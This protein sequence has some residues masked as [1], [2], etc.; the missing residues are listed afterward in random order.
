MTGVAPLMTQAKWQLIRNN[1]ALDDA[2][3][4]GLSAGV[5]NAMGLVAN[6]A[7]RVLLVGHASCTTNNPHAAGLDC[8]ACGGQSGE[9]NVKL[10]AQ[11]LNSP[12]VRGEL[13]AHNIS[14]PENTRFVACLHN[15]TSD[16]LVIFED[17]F[18]Y[19]HEAWRNWL[20]GATQAAQ[21]KRAASL[22]IA[23]N[24]TANTM[25]KSYLAKSRNW[26]EIRP[27]WGLANNAAFI[28]APRSLTQHIDL[29]CRSFLHDYECTADAEYST[30]ELIITAPM[31]VTNWI[32][33]QYYA[34]V[35]DNKKYGSGNKLLHNV[36]GGAMGVFEGNGGDL[37]IGLPLQSIH[38]G[39]DWRHQPLR[40]SVYI[41]A[42]QQAILDIV[43]R[44]KHV[45]SLINNGWLYLFQI[46]PTA[47]HISQL[48]NGQW[49]L[50]GTGVSHA[51]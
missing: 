51:A 44:H 40:L 11:L 46:D 38:D 21:Q 26:S 43:S 2:A 17:G 15:T 25:H 1:K 19:A 33:M 10:L 36:V 35:T 4:A 5:L 14:I 47:N 41:A 31:V 50:V 49:T 32:N 28:V 45:E 13:L 18:A 39:K 30:L 6:F 3:L 29:Q 27:E 23:V 16:D 48:K 24:T 42:P 20:L 34:S 7:Q 37:R 8:G 9:V 12:G 22:G